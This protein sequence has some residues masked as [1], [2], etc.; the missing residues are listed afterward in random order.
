MR[1]IRHPHTHTTLTE[2]SHNTHTTH[3]KHTHNTHTTLTQHPQNPICSRKWHRYDHLVMTSVLPVSR[4]LP[5]TQHGQGGTSWC[6]FL[7]D[8][9]GRQVARL[10][11]GKAD[12]WPEDNPGGENTQL[13]N[14][15]HTHTHIYRQTHIYTDTHTHTYRHTHI[16][17]DIYTYIYG[18]KHIHCL[19]I[20]Q[21]HTHTQRCTHTQTHTQQTQ[22][23]TVSF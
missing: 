3:T 23:H 1:N 14:H 16:H 18:H 22:T 7:F 4:A 21:T 17:T 9:P 13:V 10:H 6:H 12:A 2:H 20:V 5:L 15:T 8:L 19:K 11:R